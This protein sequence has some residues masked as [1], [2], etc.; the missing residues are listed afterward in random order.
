MSVP[1]E[2]LL[3]NGVVPLWHR[4]KFVII[5]EYTFTLIGHTVLLALLIPSR[6]NKMFPFHAKTSDM[7]GKGMARG[8]PSKREMR[9]V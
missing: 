1:P 5:M 4:E 2:A 6:Y 9:F 3:A 7:N 8:T